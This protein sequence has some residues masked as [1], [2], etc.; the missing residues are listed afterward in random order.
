MT[1]MQTKPSV[2]PALQA[3]RFN[4]PLNTTVDAQGRLIARRINRSQTRDDPST[5]SV[6]E[7]SRLHFLSLPQEIRDIIWSF[8]FVP[9]R[10]I[11]RTDCVFGSKPRL[12]SWLEHRMKAGNDL[13]TSISSTTDDTADGT[14][15]ELSQN[16]C[17]PA[18]FISKHLTAETQDI[19]WKTFSLRIDS[20]LL[21]DAACMINGDYDRGI[22]PIP[23]PKL[24]ASKLQ[25]LAIRAEH[26]YLLLMAHPRTDRDSPRFHQG[27]FE[28]LAMPA[29]KTLIVKYSLVDFAPEDG[30]LDDDD[31]EDSED[32]FGDSDEDADQDWENLIEDNYKVKDKR[33]SEHGLTCDGGED[34]E[35]EHK[36][37]FQDRLRD[38]D[39][40]RIEMLTRLL[41]FRNPFHLKIDPE[42][43][44]YLKNWRS[45]PNRVV[46]FT[47]S[48][49]HGQ[50]RLEWTP[51][52]QSAEAFPYRRID[53]AHAKK[54]REWKRRIESWL[55]LSH[56]E[57]SES[58]LQVLLSEHVYNP[59][60]AE[61]EIAPIK[62][63][64]D[65][66]EIQWFKAKEIID[67]K[68]WDK[69]NDAWTRYRANRRASKLEEVNQTRIMSIRCRHYKAV[70]GVPMN[71]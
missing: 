68:S 69:F 54:G 49:E 44:R 53:T 3:I 20:M 15:K 10:T 65:G 29:L 62:A 14:T 34:H 18:F 66:A 48:Q 52:Y 61:C 40:E 35:D 5:T 63:Y 6:V 21:R 71:T 67:E 36:D 70:G 38:M 8:V 17:H 12:E 27:V 32:D 1:D 31:E 30:W 45:T 46:H 16:F 55:F 26:V 39:I 2:Y 37:I 41:Y 19:F 58:L 43:R 51:A 23:Y 42:V 4:P 13:T 7:G 57:S 47:W 24:I 56:V 25:R 28:A 59:L 60:S 50:L 9:M 22:L 11:R 64:L 33:G